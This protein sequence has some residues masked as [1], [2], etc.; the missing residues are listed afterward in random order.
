[1]FEVVGRRSKKG[2]KKSKG[3]AGIDARGAALQI[4]LNWKAEEVRTVNCPAAEFGSPAATRLAEA[5]AR[6]LT[7]D[8][9]DLT[10]LVDYTEHCGLVT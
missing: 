6:P 10:L 8:Q 1:M 4:R 3:C 5:K 9:S 2:G 7:A